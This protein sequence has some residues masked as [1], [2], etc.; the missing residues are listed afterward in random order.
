MKVKIDWK[1]L[2]MQLWE[3]CRALARVGR[4]AT[5]KPPARAHAVKRALLRPLRGSATPRDV[6]PSRCAA[7]RRMVLLAAIGGGIV[8]VVAGCS[9]LV[10]TS[11]TQTLSVV[12]IGIPAIAVVS[13]SSQGADASGGDENK[14]TQTNPVT[15][16]VPV[17]AK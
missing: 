8:T 1:E 15:T 7:L 2:G 3:M 4:E 17:S 13:S 5:A 10:P 11:K 16:V 12:G 14:P 9:S 6:P